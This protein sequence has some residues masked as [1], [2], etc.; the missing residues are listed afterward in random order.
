LVVFVAD[1]GPP[2]VPLLLVQLRSLSVD[3]FPIYS[4]VFTLDVVFLCHT[5]RLAGELAVPGHSIERLV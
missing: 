3:C 2:N 1:E 4:P 5:A